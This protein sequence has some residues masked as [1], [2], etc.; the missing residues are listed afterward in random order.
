MSVQTANNWILNGIG[1]V[2]ADY[3][4]IF[5]E[6]AASATEGVGLRRMAE[7]DRVF[8]YDTISI[9]DDDS[10]R[11]MLK[12]VSLTDLVISSIGAD[13]ETMEAIYRNLTENGRNHVKTI[14]ARLASGN[15]IDLLVERSR[16]M[17]TEAFIEMIRE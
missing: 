8:G 13:G 7:A 6:K 17:I 14:L 10:I 12:K 15:V 3:D 9:T 11:K 4:R 16:N 1:I 2:K 5:I